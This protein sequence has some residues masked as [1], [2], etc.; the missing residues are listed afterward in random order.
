MNVER[1]GDFIV[2]SSID[3]DDLGPEPREY[4]L[5]VDEARELANTMLNVIARI[6]R[7]FE[8]PPPSSSILAHSNS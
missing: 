8:L 4:W 7:K 5:D 1:D 3:Y 2:L 6:E